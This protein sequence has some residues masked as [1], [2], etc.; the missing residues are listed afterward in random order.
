MLPNLL[1]RP[2]MRAD[3]MVVGQALVV[4]VVVEDLRAK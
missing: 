2:V 4:C 3:G 1:G